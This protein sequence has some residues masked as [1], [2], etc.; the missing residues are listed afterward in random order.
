MAQLLP[1]H[2]QQINVTLDNYEDMWPQVYP[3]LRAFWEEK[4]HHHIKNCSITDELNQVGS[5]LK[6][7]KSL[8]C[9]TASDVVQ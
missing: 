4:T 6:L 7:S 2:T 1:E 3:Q 9:N 8:V 5:E